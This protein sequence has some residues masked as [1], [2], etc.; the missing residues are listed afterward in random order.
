MELRPDGTIVRDGLEG[1]FRWRSPGQAII[2]VAGS[3]EPHTLGLMTGAQ[4]LD[5]DEDGRAYVWSR[6]SL[7]P[8]FAAGCFELRGSLIGDWTDGQESE[9]FQRDGTYVRGEARGNW[10]TADQGFLDI[11]VGM[12]VRRYRV[13]LAAPDLLVTAFDGVLIDEVPRGA[14]LVEVRIR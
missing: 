8:A 9:S 5:V 11:A 3:H 2:D 7:V 12:R 13:A 4:L 6:V 10:S 1:S 14:S